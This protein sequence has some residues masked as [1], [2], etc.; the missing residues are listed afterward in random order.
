[1]DAGGGPAPSV[2]SG[3]P[4][5]RGLLG[6][7]RILDGVG[8]AD[9]VDV[10]RE[11][12]RTTGRSDYLRMRETALDCVTVEFAFNVERH[13]AALAAVVSEP[14]QVRVV[15]GRMDPYRRSEAARQYWEPL[16]DEVFAV[17]DT[18][19]SVNGLAF[20]YDEEGPYLDVGVWP[21]NDEE[22]ARV[23]AAFTPHQVRVQEQG[24]VTPI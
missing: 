5:V 7:C 11:Y 24:P 15:A 8:Y 22:R 20:S 21:L 3:A 17:W 16:Q 19:P 1:M 12:V 14:G 4:P 9:D 2:I 18:L 10:L 13:A 23:N 6:W